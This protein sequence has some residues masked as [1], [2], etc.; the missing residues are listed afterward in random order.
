MLLPPAVFEELEQ[1]NG[2][3]R[4]LQRGGA[5]ILTTMK[6]KPAPDITNSYLDGR[7]NCTLQYRVPYVYTLL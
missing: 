5:L 7:S 3:R 1:H 4:V 2:V 6:L